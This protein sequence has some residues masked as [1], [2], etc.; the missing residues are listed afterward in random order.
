[1]EPNQRNISDDFITELFGIFSE[2]VDLSVLSIPMSKVFNIE[3][4]VKLFEIS[5]FSV[6]Y[7]TR[8]VN[9]L[10]N[11]G[12]KTLG[13]LLTLSINDLLTFKGLGE[14]SVAAI[15]KQLSAFRGQNYEQIKSL[16]KDT[17]LS[18]ERCETNKVY[19]NNL[20]DILL[21]IDL[22][23]IDDTDSFDMCIALAIEF[24]KHISNCTKTSPRNGEILQKRL[25]LLYIEKNTL[26]CISQA[27][28]ISRERVRQ[29][30][31]K[32]TRKAVSYSKR[33]KSS[34]LETAKNII[35][36]ADEAT[37]LHVLFVDFIDLYGIYYL[38]AFLQCLFDKATPEQIIELYNKYAYFEYQ[39][40]KEQTKR[41]KQIE[42]LKNVLY[43]PRER[44][45][46]NTTIKNKPFLREVNED[47]DY[48][49]GTLHLSKAGY[50]VQYES[51]LERKVLLFLENNDYVTEINTQCISIKYEYNGKERTYFPDIVIKTIENEI[52]IIEVKT[53]YQMALHQNVLKFRAMHNFCKENGMGYTVIDDKTRSIFD[54]R[55]IKY[56]T[57]VAKVLVDACNQNDKLNY[58]QYNTILSCSNLSIRMTE[59]ASLVLGEKLIWSLQPFSIS[60]E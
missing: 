42:K 29:I 12:V 4:D 35:S 57:D 53:F 34:L 58:Q 26:E 60:K 7:G 33:G 48:R 41:T 52:C 11:N 20:K 51:G 50:P 2:S 46:Y 6:L 31:N 36:K 38:K 56:N 28:G 45:K 47:N 19:F 24:E 43:F 27:Y 3:D 22:E 44:K 5:I 21:C 1:M 18:Y 54:H 25:G 13:G 23:K 8:G 37:F 15:C 55:Q 14:K 59:L 9:G 16:Q 30:V 10:A 39:K 32:M 40:N 49:T 17:A